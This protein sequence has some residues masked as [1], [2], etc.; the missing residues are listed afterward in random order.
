MVFSWAPSV[1]TKKLVT[2]P[3][4]I[5]DRKKHSQAVVKDWSSSE[6][7]QLK[8]F[9]SVP[10]SA[11]QRWHSSR[12][13]DFMLLYWIP[14]LTPPIHS[15][16]SVGVCWPQCLI[17]LLSLHFS[18]Y[19]SCVKTA[20]ILWLIMSCRLITL[21]V[22]I[23]VLPDDMNQRYRRLLSWNI[24]NVLANVLPRPDHTSI[25]PPLLWLLKP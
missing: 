22:R 10:P 5:W 19:H 15:L 21:K 1:F 23:G 13:A 24:W 17:D 20:T 18:F 3:I 6:Y 12:L 4:R 25:K 8:L 16:S 7:C 2:S 9:M 14:T 11:W